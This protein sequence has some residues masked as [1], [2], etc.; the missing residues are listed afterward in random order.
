MIGDIAGLIAAIAFALLVVFLAVP[1][2]NLGNVFTEL[3][4]SIKEMTESTGGVI[5]EASNTLATA[6]TQLEKVDEVT[7]TASQA[8]SDVAALATLFSATVGRPLVKIA[9]FSNAAKRVFTS[10]EKK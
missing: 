1:L 4:T 2:Y 9:A 5:G 8:V 6:N 10:G 3:A 7:T